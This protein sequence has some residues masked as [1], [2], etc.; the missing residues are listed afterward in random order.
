MN[1]TRLGLQDYATPLRTIIAVFPTL[2]AAQHNPLCDAAN[3]ITVTLTANADLPENTTLTLRGLTGA[4]NEN[5]SAQPVSSAH[6]RMIAGGAGA[7]EQATGTLTMIVGSAAA[8]VARAHH[9]LS[10]W[11]SPPLPPPVLSG[12]AASLTPY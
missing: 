4:Q 5:T 8:P 9:V 11:W 1:E 2:L 12:H 6:P 10:T 3:Q 7:W